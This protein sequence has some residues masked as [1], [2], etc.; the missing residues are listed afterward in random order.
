MKSIGLFRNGTICA[1]ITTAL[2]CVSCGDGTDQPDNGHLDTITDMG[3][4]DVPAADT[5]SDTMRDVADIP[6]PEDIQKDIPNQDIPDLD[7]EP[8]DALPEDA[9]DDTT[10]ATDTTDV[11]PEDTVGDVSDLA[12]TADVPDVTE[13]FVVRVPDN[14]ALE[15]TD[16]LG[17]GSYF[18]SQVDH[19]CQMS[20]EALQ[21]EFYFQADPSECGNFGN[22]QYQMHMAWI[23]IDGK[24][25]EVGAGYDYGGNHHNDSI[26]FTYAETSYEIWHSSIGWGWRA[27]ARPDCLIVCS[28]G[29]ACNHTSDMNVAQDGCSRNAGD[30]PPDLQVICVRV[31]DDGTVPEFLDP[32]T[33]QS[34]YGEE[35]DMILPCSG[36]ENYLPNPVDAFSSGE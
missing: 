15:C 21:A 27:C 20:N 25:S 11:P 4:L 13:D 18:V 30:P 5:S 34:P 35:G 23:K 31:N 28:P 16:G 6:N 7:T 29:T 2:L 3:Q 9:S 10:D 33:T 14:N 17:G 32:W 1:V 12:D 8:E 24:L 22:A 19:I 36:E 26:S